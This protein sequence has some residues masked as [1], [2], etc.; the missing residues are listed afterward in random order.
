MASP[1]ESQHSAHRILTPPRFA[2]FLAE[3]VRREMGVVRVA[4][5]YV[6]TH[7]PYP[8]MRDVECWPVRAQNYMGP[9]PV[10]CHPPCGP[11]GPCATL[12]KYQTKEGG[13]HAIEMVHRHGGVIEQPER[14]KL[15]REHARPGGQIAWFVQGDY[16]HPLPKRTQIY[17]WFP[18]RV[19]PEKSID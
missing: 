1:I 14:S 18:V 19:K 9:Y 10:I 15:F 7:G 13:L 8:R 6:A 2:A 5:L 16:G 11:W 12:C 4:A 17:F 3:W